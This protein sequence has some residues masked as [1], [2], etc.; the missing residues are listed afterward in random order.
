[1]EVSELAQVLIYCTLFFYTQEGVTSKLSY[2]FGRL[3]VFIVVFTIIL[4]G[5]LL[6]VVFLIKVAIPFFIVVLRDFCKIKMMQPAESAAEKK[7][8]DVAKDLE[9]TRINSPEKVP[10]KEISYIDN[11]SVREEQNNFSRYDEHNNYSREI[12]RREDPKAY[13]INDPRMNSA[14]VKPQ[15]YYA[16]VP[17]HQ[18]PYLMGQPQLSPLNPLQPVRFKYL[19]YLKN[20]KLWKHIIYSE[21]ITY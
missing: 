15:D 9:L 1:M 20:F 12:T 10:L 5:V 19:I 3:L 21:A 14:Y 2:Y 4:H 18:Q 13:P 6:F 16:G 7:Q 11:I 17:Q 8:E